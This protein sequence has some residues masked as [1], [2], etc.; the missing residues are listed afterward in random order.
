MNQKHS[1]MP[2]HALVNMLLEIFTVS[3]DITHF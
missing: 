3:D 1:E 2:F